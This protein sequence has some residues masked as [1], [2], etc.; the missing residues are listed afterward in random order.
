MSIT[1]R[2]ICTLALK[3]AG[4][5]GVGQ[6]ALAEDIND[7]YTALRRMIASWQKQ[8]WLVPNLTDIKA[9][10]NGSKSY[11]VG[12]AGF[13]N[14]AVRPDNLKAGYIV[15]LNTGPTP[16]SLPLAPIFSYEN[17]AQIPIKDLNSLPYSFFYDNAYP[18]GNVYIWPIGN[19][20]Y[21]AHF[22]IP[23]KIAFPDTDAGLDAVYDLPEEYEEPIH[24]NLTIRLTTMYQLQP[25]QIQVSLAKV[26]M[27][28]IRQA[29]VQVPTLRMPNGLSVG[30]SFSLW[31]AD[32][33]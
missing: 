5:L 28:V 7:A 16:V 31:N 26:G 9:T 6:T 23:A 17:Y 29:N 25:S 19:Q 32:G 30:K 21:E 15:Q 24:Y 11:T 12:P 2:R 33:Y 4:V 13:F 22:I 20:N 1:A 18:L 27:N 14:C 10:L 3:E 8:R